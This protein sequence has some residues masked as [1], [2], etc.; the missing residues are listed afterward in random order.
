[1]GK[2][3]VVVKTVG[4]LGLMERPGKRYHLDTMRPGPA[5]VLIVVPGT[6]RSITLK[7]LWSAAA[8][9]GSAT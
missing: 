4:G 6:N 5:K 7:Y 8:A 9:E 3:E 2:G 1:M